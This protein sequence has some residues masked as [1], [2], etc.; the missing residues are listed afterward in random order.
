MAL[1]TS[2]R[3]DSWPGPVT[4]EVFSASREYFVRVT[5]GE[6]I[7]DTYGFSSL[8]KGKYA[9]AEFYRR[10]PDRSYR[11]VAETTLL[12]PVA[13]L[14]FFVSDQGQLA[15]V[16]NWHNVGY[17][18]VVAIYDAGGKLVRAYDLKDL[19]SEKEIEA[20][21]HSE[22]S[23]WWRNGP[24]Y[25][26]HDQTTLLITVK[27]GDDFL[28]GMQSGQYKFCEIRDKTYRCRNN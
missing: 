23:I 12:N 7:G 24:M 4:K 5:P 16:D 9:S 14:E 8:K 19:F 26:R 21:R 20:F 25:V 17:G 10:A 2:A 18:K 3:A 27:A 15:T 28:F 11:L 6:S 1:A 13:P 22:S